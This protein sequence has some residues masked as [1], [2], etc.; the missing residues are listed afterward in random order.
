M[1]SLFQQ[2]EYVHALVQPVLTHALPLGALALVMAFLLRSRRALAVALAVTFLSS[3]AVLPTVHF[4]RA[5]ADRIQAASDEVGGQWLKVHKQ[6]AESLLWIFVAT[7]AAAASALVLIWKWPRLGK[8]LAALACTLAIS[9]SAA[10]A[11]IAKAG[12]QIRHRE[13]RSKP[14]PAVMAEPD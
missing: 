7:A 5:G 14:P 8:V 4:G 13:F 9:A 12:G 11:Y 3:A 2:P 10:G 1:I 6:R